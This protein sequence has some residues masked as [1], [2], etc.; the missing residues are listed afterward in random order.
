MYQ[1][2]KNVALP[3]L[4]GAPNRSKYPFREMDVGDSFA[5]PDEDKERLRCAASSAG[6]R[7]GR[8][9]SIRKQDDGSLRCWRLA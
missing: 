5:A 9:F 2:E 8:K 6:I 3:A 4:H 7:L 1:I